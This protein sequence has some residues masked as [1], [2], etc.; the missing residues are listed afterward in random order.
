MR[1]F[2][3][4]TAIVFS[5]F[6]T[7]A[8]RVHDRRAWLWLAVAGAFVVTLAATFHC[9]A[10]VAVGIVVIAAC[11]LARD[12]EE[13]ITLDDTLTSRTRRR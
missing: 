3:I 6:A 4:V 10:A 9:A 1:S 8:V 7:E 12:E 5:I 11:I 2:V 13:D